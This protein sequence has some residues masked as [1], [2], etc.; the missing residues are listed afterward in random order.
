M[1]FSQIHERLRL[2][3]LRRIQRG[4]LSASLL[5]RQTGFGQPHVSNFLHGR[6][7]LSLSGVDRVLLAQRLSAA[8]L[9]PVLTAR[10]GAADE[11]VG[12]VPLVAHASA[13][14]DRTIR[15]SAVQSML[16]FPAALLASLRPRAPA[17]RRAWQRFV[18]V[19]VDAADAPAM[20]PLVQPDAIAVLDRHYNSLA[21]YRP[22][23][24]TL[25]AVRYGAH[26][27]LRYVDLALNRLVLRP[28][29]LAFPVELIDAGD[30]ES[31]RDLL[32][33]RV[34]LVLNEL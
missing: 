18:A 4:T 15:P 10:G 8:D 34:A 3:M 16:H 23:R 27:K 21:T 32:A 28:R 22:D 11:D 7:Q 1:N 17:A 14:F 12:A 5:A 6:K 30:W 26:L 9:L 31:P 29:N 2:E 20:E 24:P 25:Y 19:R 13:L 33:G